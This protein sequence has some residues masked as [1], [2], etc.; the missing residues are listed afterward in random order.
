M[1]NSDKLSLFR[2]GNS[3]AH[4]LCDIP[5]YVQPTLNLFNGD[6]MK[7]NGFDNFSN[8][9]CWPYEHS[10]FNGL[11]ASRCTCWWESIDK[12]HQNS[13]YDMIDKIFDQ[14]GSGI[15]PDHAK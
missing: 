3:K 12:R 14:W 10:D 8:T 6:L 2:K 5:L 1:K 13:Q 15:Y 11:C 7:G 9:K 4:G